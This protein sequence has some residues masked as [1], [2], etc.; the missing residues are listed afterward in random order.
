MLAKLFGSKLRAKILGWLFLHPDERFFIRQLK[1]LLGEDPTNLSRELSKLEKM[2]I[3]ICQTEGRQKYFQANRR[4]PVFSELE[5]L[6]KKTVGLA[7]IL[8]ESLKPLAGRIEIAF[9]FGSV[10][11]GVPQ[12]QSDIDIMIIGSCSFADAAN[13]MTSIQNKIGREINPSVYPVAEFK[14]KVKS[15]HHFIC[16]VVREPKIFL[17]GDEDEL[18]R[19]VK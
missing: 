14:Q 6:I 4:S 18:A 2:D 12:I 7:D 17:I 8:K 5:A 9:I 10:V 15:K 3:L 13:A 11:K 19:L 16:T 1:G